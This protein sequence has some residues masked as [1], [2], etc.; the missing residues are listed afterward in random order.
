MGGGSIQGDWCVIDRSLHISH[1]FWI[2]LDGPGA[3][4]TAVYP[5]YESRGTRD[6]S[7][8]PREI[9]PGRSVDVGHPAQ[10]HL[11]LAWL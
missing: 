11:N 2:G 8:V 5:I 10:I 6:S 3:H 9:F 1:S 7:R 4:R